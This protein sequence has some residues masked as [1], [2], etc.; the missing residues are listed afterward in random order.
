MTSD[1]MVSLTVAWALE[2]VA[3]RTKEKIR[4]PGN[5]VTSDVHES[6]AITEQCLSSTLKCVSLGIMV[7][8]FVGK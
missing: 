1:A 8:P 5:L 2:A 6:L 4:S 3:H 7:A